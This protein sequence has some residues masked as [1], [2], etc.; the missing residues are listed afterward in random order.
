MF[1]RGASQ[2][3]LA[4]RMKLDCPMHL[5]LVVAVLGSLRQ[6]LKKNAKPICL[7]NRQFYAAVCA[8]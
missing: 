1:D 5:L 8:S 7:V 2:T 6:H 4:M 3:I